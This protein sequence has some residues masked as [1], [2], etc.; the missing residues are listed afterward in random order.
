M[1][2]EEIVA[3]EFVKN[4]KQIYKKKKFTYMNQILTKEILRQYLIVSKLMKFQHL[5]TLITKN[6]NLS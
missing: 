5:Q 4:L 2:N 6:L 1:N 3:S